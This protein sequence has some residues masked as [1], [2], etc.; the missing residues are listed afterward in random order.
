MLS[1]L[2]RGLAPMANKQ[3][4]PFRTLNFTSTLPNEVTFLRNS[5]AT[6]RNA[7]GKLIEAG[8]NEPCLD[9]TINGEPL[10]LRIEH[11]STNKC[12]NYNINPIDTSAFSTTGTG[13][14]SVVDDTAELLSAGLDQICTSGKVYKAEATT[15]STFA[16]YISG[17]TNNV[18]KHSMSIYARGAGG[19]GTTARLALGGAEL[20]IAETGE[21]YQRYVYENLTPDKTTRKFTIAI[22]GNETLYF[23]LNQLEESTECSSLIPVEGDDVTRPTERAYITNVDQYNWFAVEAGYMICRYTHNKFT[24]SDAYIA[25]L[26][27]GGSSN[28]IGFRVTGS[29]HD[30]KGYVRTSSSSQHASS[31]NDCQLS[32][33]L[34]SAG[35][36]WNATDADILS[37]G[38]VKNSNVSQLPIGINAL[39]IGARNGGAGSINGH[40]ASIEIG[41]RDLT[42]QQLGNRMQKP[43]DISTVGAGQSLIRGYFISQADGSDQGKQKFREIIGGNNPT[44][45]FVIID[46]STGSSAASKTTDAVNYWWDLSTSTRGPAFESFYEE[47]DDTGA[48]PTSILW[49]QGEADSHVM[50]VYTSEAQ[51]KQSLEAIFN[52]MRQTLGDIS[53]YIQHIGRNSSLTNT[54]GIQSV[55]DIQK[56]L[57]NEN[58]WCYNAAETYDLTLYDNVHLTNNAYETAAERNALALT[59]ATGAQGPI[60]NN[61]TR[62]GTTITVTITHDN[63]DDFTP[64]VSIEGF[65]FFDNTTQINVT[66]ATQI[67]SSTIQLTLA[68][69]PSS[70]IETLYYGYDDMDGVDINNVITDNAPTPMPLR[71]SKI[72]VN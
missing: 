7:M 3:I 33:V 23:I 68:S 17:N 66:N 8:L 20:P 14:I 16:V 34:V 61:T 51:Y 26:N 71:T 58:S 47:I 15:G 59:N 32:N 52:D 62:S 70:G 64:A 39:E 10:G 30:L 57:I 28:T 38:K 2:G 18:N 41:T 36:R 55:R 45:A 9:H 46:G 44:D 40:I 24:G 12:K 13:I 25:I 53:I 43:S 1:T 35:L 29:D 6:C 27:N 11:S 49:G 72:I 31:N 19:S 42:V 22:N 50:G 54:G 37:G 65:V 21:G 67:D 5:K 60:I 48:K 56:E 69:A 4:S 63:G